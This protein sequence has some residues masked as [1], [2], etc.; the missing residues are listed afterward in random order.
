MIKKTILLLLF[1]LF[2]TAFVGADTVVFQRCI[3]LFDNGVEIKE[4]LGA[5]TPEQQQKGLSGRKSPGKG[6]IFSFVGNEP[7]YFWMHN[8][9]FPL[10]I[11]FFDQ[12]GRLFKV[13]DM[14]ANTDD[15]HSSESP[16][17]YALELPLGRFNQLGL[18]TGVAL[19]KKDCQ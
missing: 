4:V 9:H 12:Q 5:H 3:L 1:N 15:V 17:Q 16:A 7:A 14:Q 6:M 13:T 19:V 10:S 2:F 8:T 11:G 18:N